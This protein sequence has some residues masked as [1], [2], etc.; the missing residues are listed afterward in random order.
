VLYCGGGG[1]FYYGIFIDAGSCFETTKVRHVM[2]GGEY[3]VL[4]QVSHWERP[5][6]TGVFLHSKDHYLI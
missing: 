4:Q 1:M 5:S 2:D 6:L 3:I